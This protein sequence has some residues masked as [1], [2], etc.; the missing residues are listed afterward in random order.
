MLEHD[1]LFS[2]PHLWPYE[3]LKSEA[4]RFKGLTPQLNKAQK[5]DL[6]RLK[7]VMN[8]KKPALCHA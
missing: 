5:S 1:V 4:E 8:K 3:W 7:R 6:R 2:K